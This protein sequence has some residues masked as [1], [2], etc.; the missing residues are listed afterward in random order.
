MHFY[1]HFFYYIMRVTVSHTKINYNQHLLITSKILARSSTKTDIQ[2]PLY[3]DIKT[4]RD[5]N[6]RSLSI[7]LQSHY[8]AVLLNYGVKNYYRG[9]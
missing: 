8:H 6:N 5:K 4:I 7:K 3:R 1:E 9:C 2:N